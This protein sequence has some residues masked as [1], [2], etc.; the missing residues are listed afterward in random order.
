MIREMLQKEG[1]IPRLMPG[2]MKGPRHRGG[3][4]VMDMGGNEAK[5][6]VFADGPGKAAG[7]EVF[8][9]AQAFPDQGFGS[10]PRVKGHRPGYGTATMRE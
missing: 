2:F 9:Q 7:Q 6:Q 4:H 1:G 8:L 5:P 10:G 3:L